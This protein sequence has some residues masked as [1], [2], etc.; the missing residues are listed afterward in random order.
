MQEEFSVFRIE[1]CGIGRQQVGGEI[2]SELQRVTG[3]PFAGL[4][5]NPARVLA[6]SFKLETHSDITDNGLSQSLATAFRQKRRVAGSI[7]DPGQS[8]FASLVGNSRRRCRLAETAAAAAAAASAAA[9]AAA[10]TTA[11]ATP[12]P[13]TSA[14]ATTATP[15]HLLQGAAVVFLVEQMECRQAD[16]RDFLFTQRDCL[17]RCDVEFLRDVR[18]RR[19]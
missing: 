7:V 10:A 4:A 3:L 1:A 5:M 18:S 6:I 8:I 9:A 17:C 14:P 16:V 12:A 15:R 11:T 19:G 13:A 2:R